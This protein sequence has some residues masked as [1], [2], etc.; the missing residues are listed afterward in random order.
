MPTIQQVE[1]KPTYSTHL[2]ESVTLLLAESGVLLFQ[3]ADARQQPVALLD[4]F[5]Q[6][7]SLS[8]LCPW[9]LLHWI[10][11]IHFC[12]LLTLS[13]LTFCVHSG[14]TLHSHLLLTLLLLGPLG[15]IQ[16]YSKFLPLILLHYNN[17]PG[18]NTTTT[19]SSVYSSLSFSGGKKRAEIHNKLPLVVHRYK[20]SC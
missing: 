13:S 2:N 10:N 1:S 8:H 5:L 7:L 16:N 12:L 14:L 17:S 4:G 18:S 15:P 20:A 11:P 6:L 9:K 19:H 3:L